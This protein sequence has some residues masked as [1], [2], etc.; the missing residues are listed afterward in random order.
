MVVVADVREEWGDKVD[1]IR[2]VQVGWAAWLCGSGGAGHSMHEAIEGVESA[3][4]L[5]GGGRSCC[6]IPA[7]CQ[8]RHVV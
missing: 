6:P 7:L 3:A 5:H 2:S 8:V 4:Q 1:T